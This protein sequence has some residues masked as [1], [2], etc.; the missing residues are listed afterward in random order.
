MKLEMAEGSYGG[1]QW[2]SSYYDITTVDWTTFGHFDHPVSDGSFLP[3]FESLNWRIPSYETTQPDTGSDK[4]K[5]YSK[6]EFTFGVQRKLAEDFSFTARFLHNRILWAIED[7]G[8]QTPA[9]EAYYTGNP[10]SDWVNS[11]WAPGYWLTPKAKKNYYSVDI[12]LDKRFSNN[13]LG[14]IHYTWSH[15]WG[16]FSGL[17]SSDEQGRKSPNVERFFDA[18]FMHYD[19]NGNEST[20]KLP[21]DRPHQFKVY[22]AY[23]FDWGLTVGASAFG[24]S[25]TPISVE[26]ELNNI[27][28]YY[29]VGRGTEGRNPFLWRLDLYAEYN[30]KITDRYAIQ[31]NLNVLNVFNTHIALRRFHLIN[32]EDV[33]LDDDEILAGYDYLQVIQDHDVLGDPRYQKEWTFQAPITARIGVKFIF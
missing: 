6:L 27:Q 17:A 16:N 30:L 2:I 32:Q 20:G 15:L 33:Y 26:F 11:F 18:W 12:G 25:G 21:T 10:G 29:P 19:Q 1:F 5:P 14:G 8:V 9:G 7:I 3:Y 22:G 13:W 4:L 23:A 28:G 24:M 31:F